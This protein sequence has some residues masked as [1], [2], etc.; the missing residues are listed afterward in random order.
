MGTKQKNRAYKRK[1][2]NRP[3][4]F[5]LSAITDGR[6]ETIHMSG[7]AINISSGGIGLSTTCRL[8]RGEILKLYLPAIARSAALPV[9]SEVVWVKQAGGNVEAGVRIFGLDKEMGFLL[10]ETWKL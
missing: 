10:S 3:V 8:E 1:I 5:E 9:F 4:S 7:E 6:R 2:F